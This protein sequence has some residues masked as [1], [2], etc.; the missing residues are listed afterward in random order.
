[1]GG[2]VSLKGG[3]LLESRFGR[4]AIIAQLRQDGGN[5]G[6]L[7]LGA[8]MIVGSLGEAHGGFA[9]ALERCLGFFHPDAS[10]L[11]L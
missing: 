6:D 3:N 8:G 1:M 2:L 11:R 5:L 7:A 10:Q 9:R 4:G